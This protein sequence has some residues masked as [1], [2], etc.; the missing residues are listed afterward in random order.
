MDPRLRAADTDREHVAE[1]LQRH[2][3]AGRLTLDEYEQRVTAVWRATT[4]GELAALTADLPDGQPHR[5]AAGRLPTAVMVAATALVAFLV[6]AGLLAA[7]GG[8]GWA[9]MGPMMNNMG[10]MT[11]CH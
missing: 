10:S 1:L 5:R 2:T 4:L 3:T 7:T 9:H 8:A 6:L 11:G